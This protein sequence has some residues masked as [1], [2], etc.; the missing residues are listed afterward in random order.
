MTD[1]GGRRP[2]L[3]EAVEVWSSMND[4]SL[5]RSVAAVILG[6]ALLTLGS[7][8][9][10]RLVIGATGIGSGDPVTALFIGASLGSRL[11]LAVAA[12]YLTARAA[13]RAPRLHAG[14][15]AGVLAFFSLA[16]IGGLTA[17]GG[18]E[19]PAWYPTVMLFVG[20]VGV[21]IGGALRNE[22]SQVERA[23]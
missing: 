6:F 4:T 18:L 8:L 7:V 20:P 15:L 11:L 22:P 1:S 23:G 9:A 14:A 16:A 12:G 5:L 21:V 13:P 3:D 19:D 10:G 2:D 17:A